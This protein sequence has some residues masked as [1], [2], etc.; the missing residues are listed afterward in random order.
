MSIGKKIFFQLT[1]LREWVEY[2]IMLAT[3]TNYQDRIKQGKR[4]EHLI[5]A[6]MRTRN[7]SIKFDEPT[8]N[9]DCN[10]KIDAWLVNPKGTRY[11]V[12]VKYRETGDDILFEVVKNTATWELGRDLQ[13]V[14]QLYLV[15]NREGTARLFW[16]APLK[17]LA[18]KLM[19]QAKQDLTDNPNRVLWADKNFEMKHTT[20]HAHG[21]RKLVAFF[22]PRYFSVL[23]KWDNLL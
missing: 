19:E 22:N 21:N 12:Q 7:P 3:I 4:V 20:D 10:A 15:V 13:S 2:R 18:Q 11:S 17:A 6:N 5:L 9:E 16:T 14:A 1:N 23:G 8:V